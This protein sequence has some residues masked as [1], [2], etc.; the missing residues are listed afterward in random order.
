MPDHPSQPAARPKPLVGAG[1][2]LLLLLALC[3]C[4]GA[5][6]G[7]SLHA[8]TRDVNGCAAALPAARASV[9]G[10]PQLAEIHSIGA[11]TALRILRMAGR[12]PLPHHNLRGHVCVVA[13]RGAFRRRQ[14]PLAPT[15]AGQYAVVM[16]SLRHPEVL[17][18]ALVNALPA[19]V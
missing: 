16:V 4:S 3:G 1:L 15:E 2:S 11:A 6:G 10:R 17:A 12:A 9:P 7:T 8:V 19:G 18:L 14:V 13:F 5:R